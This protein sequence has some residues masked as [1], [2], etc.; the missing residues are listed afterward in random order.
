[1][2]EHIPNII[3]TIENNIK[4]NIYQHFKI[5]VLL[6]ITKIIETGNIHISKTPTKLPTKETN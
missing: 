4:K 1:M 3:N 6:L 5:L 2:N